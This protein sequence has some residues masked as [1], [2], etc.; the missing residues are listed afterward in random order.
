MRF[1][2]CVV[3]WVLILVSALTSRADEAAGSALS[4]VTGSKFQVAEPFEFQ[5][6]TE[7]PRGSVVHFP[8]I[9]DRLG[10]FEVLGLTDQ[11]DV[12][13]ADRDDLRTWTRTIRLETLSTGSFE[14]PA[15]EILVVGPDRKSEPL[16]TT[17]HLVKV[18][19]VLEDRA[20]PTVFRDIRDVVDVTFDSPKSYAWVGWTV[21]AGSVL[22]C[23]AGLAIVRARRKRWMTPAEWAELEIMELQSDMDNDCPARELLARLDGVVRVY[24]EN[25]FLFPATSY[26]GNQMIDELKGWGATVSMCKKMRALFQIAEEAKFADLNLSRTEVAARIQDTHLIIDE[27]Q[28]LSC[29]EKE[30]A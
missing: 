25:E 8:T 10:E 1:A 13:H 18:M 21:V 6:W 19:S 14:L 11:E 30:A 26:T 20:D 24:L 29:A 22:A 12:P 15:L 3:A 17:P 16:R 28:A 9:G 5:V 23:L 4:R 27:L 2:S 7:V